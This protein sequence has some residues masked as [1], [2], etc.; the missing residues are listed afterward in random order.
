[1]KTTFNALAKGTIIAAM[2]LVAMPAI[3]AQEKID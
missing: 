3:N 1:M 2:S